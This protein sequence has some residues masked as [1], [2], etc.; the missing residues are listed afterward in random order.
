MKDLARYR[1]LIRIQTF[2]DIR[3]QLGRVGKNAGLPADVEAA[4]KV[5]VRD[6]WRLILWYIRL[7]RAARRDYVP[8]SLID[9][10]LHLQ[11]QRTFNGVQRVKTANLR[12]YTPNYGS[13]GEESSEVEDPM[14]QLYPADEEPGDDITNVTEE[15]L[16][17][18]DPE[19]M[20]DHMTR[21][22]KMMTSA[23]NLRAF[24]QGI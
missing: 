20:R 23:E 14:Q 6:W 5:V 3:K 24:L 21:V 2:V 1:P 11:R 22:N 12:D 18:Y 13:D 7:R 4:R 15:Q 8:I 17:N 9:V 16:L 19:R 10:E